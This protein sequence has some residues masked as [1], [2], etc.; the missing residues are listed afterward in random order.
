MRKNVEFKNTIIV[1]TSNIG[2]S[3]LLEGTDDYSVYVQ[4]GRTSIDGTINGEMVIVIV[5]DYM[6]TEPEVG[7]NG[8]NVNFYE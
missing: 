2:S 5:N 4:A 6:T 8:V 1:M 3:F 7:M